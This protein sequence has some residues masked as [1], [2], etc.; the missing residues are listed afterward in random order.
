MKSSYRAR[1]LFWRWRAVRQHNPL[2]RRSTGAQRIAVGVTVLVVLAAAVGGVFAVV[3]THSATVV[4][5][6]RQAADSHQVTATVQAVDDPADAMFAEGDT[7]G[8]ASAHTVRLSW[9]WQGRRLS[10]SESLM[11]PPAQGSTTTVWVNGA[12]ELVPHPLTAADQTLVI[13]GVAL[14]MALLVAIVALAAGRLYGA[15]NLRRRAESWSAAWAAVA[16]LWSRD[17]GFR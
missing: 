5:A 3:A 17:H 10:G 1:R 12:G 16:P 14:G 4:G 6:R 13:A 7:E 9:S 2:L 11:R 15:W 8:A